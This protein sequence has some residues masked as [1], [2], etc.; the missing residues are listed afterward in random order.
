MRIYP[1]IEVLLAGLLIASCAGA[2]S[3]HTQDTSTTITTTEGTNLEIVASP[4]GRRLVMNLQNVLWSVPI[5]GGK[6]S[7]LTEPFL[8]PVRL[9]WS[10]DGR[11]LV[12]Q[13]YRDGMFHLYT[14]QPDGTGIR[15]ITHGDYDD[16]SPR[17]SPDGKRIA[18][19]SERGG[20]RDLWVLDVASGKARVV[21]APQDGRRGPD[22]S[23]PAGMM[24]VPG[25]IAD[26]AWSPD[27]RHIAFVRNKTLEAIDLDTGA[28][29]VLLAGPVFDLA[30]PSWSRDGRHIAVRQKGGLWLIA[31]EGGPDAAR[32]IGDKSD[33]NPFPAVWLPGGELLYGAAGG[34]WVSAIES[35][36]SRQ[37][38]FE[39]SFRLDRPAYRR[40]AYD[41][42]SEQPQPVKGIVAPAISP[43]GRRVVFKALN[44]L[45]LHEIGGSSKRLMH[46]T[47]YETDPA[48][49]PDGNRIAYASDRVGSQDLYVLDWRTGAE[50]R[51]TDLPG[52]E[53]APAWSN[54]GRHLA[55]ETQDG[56]LVVVTPGSAE[57]R[58]LVKGLNAPGRPSWSAD[59]RTIALAVLHNARNHI[60]TVDVETGEQRHQEPR[61]GSSISTRGDDGPVWSAD[62]KFMVFSM[63]STLWSLPVSADGTI[64]GAPKQLTHAASD[65]PS[66]SRDG[67]KLL[68]LRNGELVLLDQPTGKERVLPT[69]I[70]WKQDKPKQ[71]VLIRNVRV[72][73]GVHEQAVEAQDV[74]VVDE[75]ITAI[76]AHA[77]GEI[78]PGVRSIDGTGRTLV[79]GLFDMHNHQQHRS[80]FLGDRQGRAWLAYGVTTTRSTGDQAYRALE[81]KESLASGD[82][83]G[84]RHF[85]TGEMFEGR[86][87]EWQ[88][89]RP[90]ESRQQLALDL[91]RAE[92][93]GFDVIKTYVRLPF[94]YQ[95]EIVKFAHERMG[96]SVT[97][98]YFHPGVTYGQDGSEHGGGPTRW[99]MSNTGGYYDDVV[100]AMAKT[101]FQI[102]TTNFSS[103]IGLAQD[104]AFANDQRIKAL[105]PQ[106][107]QESVRNLVLCAQ[108]KGPCGFLPPNE[109]WA[110]GA[111]ERVTQL[112]RAG[113]T[114]MVGSDAP[115]DNYALSTQLNIRALAK[116]GMTNF[117]ALQA[118]TIV[119]ARAQGVDQDLGS[120][121]VGKLADLVLIDGDPSRD[122]DELAN[123]R[124]VLKGGRVYT[125]EELMAPFS[126]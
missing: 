116:Y 55:F 51:I 124:M 99:E 115:L 114:V 103:A 12:M 73:D 49:S 109:Q 19:V 25:W 63:A 26:P 22:V 79:P 28:V 108:G 111:V 47:Y 23:A 35:G 30:A 77:P 97:A 17:W 27:G 107:E 11:Q 32:R 29:R 89:A 3:I 91:S 46:D 57:V 18:F 125:I 54:D 62:G 9:D 71:R 64:A 102:T 119:P 67:R 68:Y 40:K 8:E 4:D 65:A 81:D 74:L 104:E 41:F 126:N 82:R 85:M 37:I 59:G 66:L 72:W 120:I 93:L 122:M 15:Q 100:Q 38:P 92:A 60:L 16:L 34:I 88:F 2:G 70:T 118:A 14:L 24:G 86:S 94:D 1:Q 113:V 10:P 106:W 87:L 110:R 6:A 45:W 75:R 76:S 52:A 80:K 105:Y 112:K 36:D 42:S 5:E 7:R 58:T 123:V 20:N 78:D 48:W 50:Q 84:P 31:A 39:V 56:D 53:V 83:V 43:D 101:H 95:T 117:E 61:T 21:Y 13:S 33:V 69:G 98:H 44:D 96:I 90:I 121:E